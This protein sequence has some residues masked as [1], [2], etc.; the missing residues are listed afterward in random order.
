[1]QTELFDE[2]PT[3]KIKTKSNSKSIFEEQQ[4]FLT[5]K[6]GPDWYRGE[7]PR[8]NGKKRKRRRAKR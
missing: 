1:M 7:D 2:K 6:Y 3:S 8:N 4:E 5:R